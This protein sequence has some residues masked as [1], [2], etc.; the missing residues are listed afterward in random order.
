MKKTVVLL[1]IAGLL[2][3]TA[4]GM[5]IA[6]GLP[7]G[8]SPDDIEKTPDTLNVPDED[9]GVDEMNPGDGSDITFDIGDIVLPGEGEES[10]TDMMIAEYFSITGNVVS[11]E[12]VD[13]KTQVTIEDLD[14]NPAVL[15]LDESTVF[16]FAEEF[17]AGDTVTGWYLTNAP[18][19]MIWPPVY[20]ISV[21]AAGV[22]DGVNIKVDRFFTWEENDGGYM[23]SRDKMFAFQTDENTEIVLVNGDDFSDGEIGGRRIVVIYGVSTRSIPE[24]ATADKLIVLYENIVALS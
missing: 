21:L 18:M 5:A 9:I 6:Y 4:A 11:V 14:G 13:G 20:N 24:M 12:V 15:V 7:N 1:L 17:V 23:I 3:G 22:P 10:N 16:P 8:A 19:I 2:V